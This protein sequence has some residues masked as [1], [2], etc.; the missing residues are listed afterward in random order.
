M[1]SGNSCWFHDNGYRFKAFRKRQQ[2]LMTNAGGVI[3]EL[4]ALSSITNCCN[5]GVRACRCDLN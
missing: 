2:L 5:G 1:L 4:S 3:V